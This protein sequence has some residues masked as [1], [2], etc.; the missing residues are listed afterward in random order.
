MKYLDFAEQFKNFNAISFQDVK[1][2]FGAVNYAQL[3]GWKK[4][5]LLKYAKR[6]FFILPNSKIDLHILANELNYSYISMEYALSH[7]QIIPDIAQTITS[8]SKNRNEKIHNE[9]GSFIYQKITKGLFVD[10]ELFESKKENR[11]FR[12]ATPEK[13]LFDLIYL[14]SDL[15]EP[16]DFES[17]RLTLQKDFKISKL[18]KFTALVKAARIKNRLNSLTSYLYDRVK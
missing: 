15:S 5:G 1:N 12:M 10:Y 6:G 4:K 11:L 13:A 17:L 14:R 3:T 8:I 7:Y 2:A 18:K 9:F 16:K